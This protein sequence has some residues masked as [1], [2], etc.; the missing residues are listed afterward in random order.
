MEYFI[1]SGDRAAFLKYPMVSV[2]CSYSYFSLIAIEITI[3]AID[4]ITY[5]L[6]TEEP[7]KK[8]ASD[9]YEYSG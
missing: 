8:M 3:Q 4:N 9:Q 6:L 5:Q 2:F 1:D 7:K